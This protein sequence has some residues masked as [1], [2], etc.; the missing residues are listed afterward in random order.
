MSTGSI[1]D[2]EH[3]QRRVL[4]EMAT[5][6]A[7]SATAAAES[8]LPPLGWHLDEEPATAVRTLRARGERGEM[9]CIGL[10][11]TA[12]SSMR[13]WSV[14]PMRIRF[15][16][17]GI[18]REHVVWRRRRGALHQS[19]GGRMVDPVTSRPPRDR[20]WRG[21]VYEAERRGTNGRPAGP[22]VWQDRRQ[23][24]R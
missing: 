12:R 11:D 6:M 22:H 14:V 10:L 20:A 23:Q 5:A 18:A 16:L 17:T 9:D 8:P 24:G 15:R 13:I 2:D 3:R 7:W 1:L 21:A 4:V 19:C